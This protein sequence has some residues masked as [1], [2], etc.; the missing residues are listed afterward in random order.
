MMLHSAVYLLQSHKN[1]L[2]LGL[3]WSNLPT[4]TDYLKYQ[5]SALAGNRTDI[6]KRIQ[7]GV[8]N[9]V[10]LDYK[11]TCVLK[12]LCTNHLSCSN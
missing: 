12:E 9:P 5:L 6:I 7:C 10:S 11:D 8:A 1:V 3:T 2:S 4:L